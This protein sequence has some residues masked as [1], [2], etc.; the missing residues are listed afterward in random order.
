MPIMI[1]L[2]L[3]AVRPV[4][5]D[6]RQLHG[7]ACALFAAHGGQESPFAV[8]PLRSTVPGSAHEWTWRA[9][10]LPGG[11]PPEG[12]MARTELRLGHVTCA[13]TEVT[14]RLVTHAHL[15]AGP[16]LDSARL[17]FSSPTYFSQNG[18][19]TVLPDPRLILGSQTVPGLV[20]LQGGGS[21]T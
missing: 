5:P 1:E 20:A 21:A 15:A 6:T 17:A 12:L 9:A 4:Q 19:D 10:W 8:G 13:V 18:T 11:P 3:K 14:H 16:P 2:R 7:M